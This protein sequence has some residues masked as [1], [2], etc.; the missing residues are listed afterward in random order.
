MEVTHCFTASVMAFFLWKCCPCS[1]SFISPNRWKTKSAKSGLYGGHVGTFQSTLAMYFMVF[2]LVWSLM[3]S[4]CKRK[5]VFF[6]DLGLGVWVFSSVSVMISCQSWWFVRVPENTKR[7]PLSYSQRRS[8]SPYPLMAFSWTSSMVN[9]K[10]DAPWTT[11]LTPAH[12]S[13]TISHHS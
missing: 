13:D 4:C 7:S 5:V 1:S 8:T 3:L 12:S 6:S 2:K 10:A 11:V 9:S